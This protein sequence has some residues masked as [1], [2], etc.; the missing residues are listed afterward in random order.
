M[1]KIDLK[2]ENKEFYYPSTK[3]VSV[4]ELPLMK[5]LMIDGQGDPNTS[6]EYQDAMETIFPV[7]YKT[8]FT[9]KKEK[10]QD[11][12][13][14]PLEGLWWTDK[15][16]EFS[17]AD[18]GSWKWTVMIRQ[19]DFIRQNTINKAI[20]E[21]E[22]KKDLPALSKLRFED[23][24]EGKAVQIM[25]I[26]PYGEAEAHAVRKLHDFIENKGYKLSGK[27]HEIYISDMRRTKPEKLK[28]IIRQ[29]FE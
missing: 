21:L 5:F 14:M 10:S 18:K 26:G 23:F 25:H 3:E 17:M 20:K 22:K 6:K 11:Y 12:V 19:P 16:E 24:Q 9:S 15:M 28:T 2:K 8:K 7:S 4:V 13:V 1:P 27:H 29:P